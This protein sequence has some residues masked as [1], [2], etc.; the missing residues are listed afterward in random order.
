MQNLSR[1]LGVTVTFHDDGDVFGR[2]LKAH[3]GRDQQVAQGHK[4]GVAPISGRFKDGREKVKEFEEDKLHN[5]GLIK[6]A[7]WSLAYTLVWTV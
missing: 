2:L 6:L 7:P 4:D 3:F 1:L 5:H